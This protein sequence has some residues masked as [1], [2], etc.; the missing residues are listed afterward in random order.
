MC[1]IIGYVGKDNCAVEICIEGIQVLQFRGYD[2]C[3]ICTYNETKKEFQITKYASEIPHLRNK[4]N[5]DTKNFDCIERL[6]NEVIV[7]HEKS[8][9]GIGHTRWA[10]H[11]KKV[12]KNAHPHIDNSGKIALVHNGIIDNFKEIKEFLNKEGI[13]LKSETDTEVIVQLIGLFYSRGMT[14]TES[15]KE[16]LEKH[17]LGT[18]ALLIVCIDEPTK[19]IATRNGS[20]LLVGV[21]EDFYVVSSDSYAFQKYTSDYFMIG[22]R[23]LV[24]LSSEKKL[25]NVILRQAKV[26]EIYKNPI[27]GFDYFLLQ[28]IME[29]PETLKRAMNYGSRFKKIGNHFEVNLGG[30]NEHVDYLRKAKNLIIIATGTSYF[31]SCFVGGLIKKLDCFNTVQIIDACSFDESDIPKDNPI[32]IFVSQS[33]ESKDVLN[34]FGIIK[35]KGIICIGIVNKVESTLA[36]EVLCGVFINAGREISVASTKAFSGQ[37]ICLTLVGLFFFQIKNESKSFIIFIKISFF[38]K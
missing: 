21:G 14:F 28:E 20:P 1:G 33:G 12:N 4:Q 23:E 36:R 9:L 24:E 13:E 37:F 2:S 25:T 34:A 5:D 32:A 38:L 19:L 7:T 29:Q 11:G 35:S 31:A 15:I 17:I 18:Y 10:T 27:E 16:A 26:E 30:L 8:K 3:G 6:C 22:S